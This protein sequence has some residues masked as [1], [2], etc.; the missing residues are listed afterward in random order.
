LGEDLDSGGG[1]CGGG[2][3]MQH[4]PRWQVAWT[5]MVGAQWRRMWRRSEARG[6]NLDGG[7]AGGLDFNGRHA[8][9]THVKEERGTGVEAIGAASRW[10]RRRSWGRW[11]CGREMIGL[12]FRGSG[13]L[14]KKNSSDRHDDVFDA[15]RYI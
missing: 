10:T 9:E 8:V 4:E 3:G 6:V 14:K 2:A 13:T 12:R 15:H 11:V 7:H 5:S 1:A